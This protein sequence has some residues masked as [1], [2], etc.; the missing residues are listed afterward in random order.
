M[1]TATMAAEPFTITKRSSSRLAREDVP[2]LLAQMGRLNQTPDGSRCR[3]S[4]RRRAAAVP[5][6][7]GDDGH[8]WASCGSRPVL[9]ELGAA[10]HVE[11]RHLE[12]PARLKES[13]RI[14]IT[15][16]H[17]RRTATRR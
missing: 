17:D 15:F 16:R 12:P 10:V 2:A 1:T 9:L 3:S 11:R 4:S 5:R 14:A 13:R 6:P 8:L 7:G